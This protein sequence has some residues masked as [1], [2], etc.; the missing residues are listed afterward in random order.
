[1]ST[2]LSTLGQVHTIISLVAL[3]AGIVSLASYRKI[4]ASSRS[5]ALYI[6]A[7]VLTCVTGFGIFAHGGWGAPHNLGVIT[8]LTLGAAWLA[9]KGKV[10]GGAAPYVEVVAYSATLLFHMIPAITETSTR[11]PLGAPLLANA[12]APE[13][14]AATGVLFLL[15]LAGSG[16]Q[17]RSL[18]SQRQAL[19]TPAF[20]KGIV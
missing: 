13:L 3:G 2:G 14:K 11:L 9:G 1:M 17:V 16:L 20:K 18:R 5:G 6:W 12:D 4:A 15:F 8:L 19:F 7:T 10:F